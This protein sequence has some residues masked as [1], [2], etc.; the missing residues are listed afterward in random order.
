[1]QRT[2]HFKN[3]GN[4]NGKWSQIGFA[5]RPH[6]INGSMEDFIPPL[7]HLVGEAGGVAFLECSMQK[8]HKRCYC[9]LLHSTDHALSVHEPSTLQ[10]PL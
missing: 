5:P 8:C 3:K 6:T 10:V 9:V 7:G 2:S 4:K 1:M